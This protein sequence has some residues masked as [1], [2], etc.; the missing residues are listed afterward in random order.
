MVV[1]TNIYIRAFREEAFGERFRAWHSAN[2]RQLAMSTVVL[3]ELMVGAATK[4]VRHRLE[5]DYVRA[6]RRM[7]RLL[8]PSQPVWEK[9]ATAEAELRLKKGHVAR[10]ERRGFANDLLIA[11]T[12]RAVGATLL[13]ENTRDFELIRS[14]TGVRHTPGTI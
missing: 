13:T 1:D 14:V 6:F 12:C 7:N 4:S 9:A 8:T 3:Y 2:A 5:A 10:I 11:L